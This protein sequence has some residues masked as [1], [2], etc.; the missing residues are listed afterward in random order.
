MNFSRHMLYLP[1]LSTVMLVIVAVALSSSIERFSG[2]AKY[3]QEVL[4]LIFV[5][6]SLLDVLYF[7]PKF[8]REK[9]LPAGS[10]DEVVEYALKPLVLTEMPV[11]FG[12]ILFFLYGSWF[13][14]SI[15][16]LFNLVSWLYFYRKIE[17]KL[18]QVQ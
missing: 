11:L 13:Y 17:N 7:V 18:S 2:S 10:E 9:V 8:M 16:L 6:I 4:L 14:F 5:F 3:P 1:L 15:F 12:F